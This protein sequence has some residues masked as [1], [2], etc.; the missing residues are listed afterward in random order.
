MADTSLPFGPIIRMIL[1]GPRNLGWS[2]LVPTLKC[3]F[4]VLSR[5]SS[6]ASKG[7]SLRCLS[8]WVEFLSCAACN[9]AFTV[10]S[11]LSMSLMTMSSEG[12]LSVACSMVLKVVGWVPVFKKNGVSPVDSDF[13]LFIAK[14]TIG[15]NS[16]QLVCCALIKARSTSSTTRFIRSV[17]PSVCG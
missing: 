6:P 14:V 1:K 11:V 8:A 16:S 13:E 2:F 4:F 7:W 12:N 3:K 9:N 5:T 15:I 17:C 10:L